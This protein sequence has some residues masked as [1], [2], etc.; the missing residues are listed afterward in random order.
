MSPYQG[1]TDSPGG[2]NRRPMGVTRGLF[3]LIN[4]SSNFDDKFHFDQVSDPRVS[5]K[6]DVCGFPILY[7]RVV[8]FLL[9]IFLIDEYACKELHFHILNSN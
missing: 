4:F 1:S 2:F 5:A 7:I 3:F 9:E 6:M 8:H